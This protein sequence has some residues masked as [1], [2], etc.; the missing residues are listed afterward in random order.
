MQNNQ[1]NYFGGL[2]QLNWFN[3]NAG[4]LSVKTGGG[5]G[6]WLKF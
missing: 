5:G 3:T 4:L 6:M 2:N 1:F